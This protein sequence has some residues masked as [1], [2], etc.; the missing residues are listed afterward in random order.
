MFFLT[1]KMTRQL[2]L[3]WISLKII[4]ALFPFFRT[5]GRKI[6]K[7]T[8]MYKTGWDYITQNKEKLPMGSPPIPV[9]SGVDRVTREGTVL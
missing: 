8:H 7:S 6:R 1:H 2:H 9:T 4:K 3:H 5:L